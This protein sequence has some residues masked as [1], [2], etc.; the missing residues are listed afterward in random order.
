MPSGRPLTSKDDRGSRDHVDHV[1]ITFRLK[2]HVSCHLSH[3]LSVGVAKEGRKH[4]EDVFCSFLFGR[5]P[6]LLVF[7]IFVYLVYLVQASVFN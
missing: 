2:C 3:L 1:D 5:K 4:S 6:K 7:G